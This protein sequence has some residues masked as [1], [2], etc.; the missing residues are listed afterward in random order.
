MLHLVSYENNHLLHLKIGFVVKIRHIA[1]TT[2][3]WLYALV[4]V[5]LSTSY[6]DLI[7]TVV[8]YIRKFVYDQKIDF[9]IMFTLSVNIRDIPHSPAQ[10]S[11]TYKAVAR[12]LNSP[13]PERQSDAWH[14]ES[15]YWMTLWAFWTW[16]G[17]NRL[18]NEY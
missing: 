2:V 4:I 7:N 3:F 6:R 13:L 5:Y 14:A 9:M 8:L 1:I 12:S 15:C 17:L 16:P 10:Q 11:A 18:R